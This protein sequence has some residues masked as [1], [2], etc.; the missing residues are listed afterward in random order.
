MLGLSRNQLLF[1]IDDIESNNKRFIPGTDLQV[2]HSSADRVNQVDTILVTAPTHIQEIVQKK[3]NYLHDKSVY[4]TTPG[5][6][7][8]SFPTI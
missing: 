3:I 6:S 1:V 4:S 5:F 7:R 2:I 8:L